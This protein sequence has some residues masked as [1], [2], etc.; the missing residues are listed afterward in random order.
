MTRAEYQGFVIDARPH[1]LVDDGRW[2]LAISI[3]RHHGDGDTVLSYSAADT[4]E[5]KE[6]AI[7]YCLNFGRQIIDGKVDGCVAP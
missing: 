3:E 6:E 7:D 4:F 2:S 1:Q 5:T